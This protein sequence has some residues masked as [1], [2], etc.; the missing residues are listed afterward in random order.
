MSQE[1]NPE[2][3]EESVTP[4]SVDLY[5]DIFTV[6]LIKWDFATEHVDEIGLDPHQ[7]FVVDRELALMHKIWSEALAENLGLDETT[8]RSVEIDVWR[9]RQVAHDAFGIAPR[10]IPHSNPQTS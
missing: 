9:A 5:K 7:R 3:P 10:Q 8:R 6:G 4:L 2:N 1:Q